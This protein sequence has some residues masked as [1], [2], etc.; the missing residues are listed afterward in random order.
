MKRTRA[1]T[2]VASLKRPRVAS[3]PAPLAPDKIAAEAVA[4]LKR[5]ASAK[6]RDGMGRYGIPSDKAL[7]VSVGTLHQV[8][9]KIGRSQE[10][11]E[12][13]W[14]TGVYEARLLAA[15]VG[16]AEK[17]TVAGMD[18]WCRGFDNWAVVD[19]VCF[20][21]FDRSPLAWG[22]VKPW[23]RQRGEFQ[24]RAG[25]VLLACLAAHGDPEEADLVRYLPLIEWGAADERNFVKK[26][27][28]WALRMMGRKSPVVR[29]AAR[30]TAQKLADSENA[31][32]RWVGRDALRDL[33]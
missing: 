4:E 8:A 20:K 18:R 19:T 6:V 27:V 15:F 32:A 1:R 9:R 22:R 24:R 33:K 23:A 2:A 28:S 29:S 12:L 30:D 25:F 11:A 7:G 3:K 21:L 17:L 14:E 31:S 5:L 13:L 16:E 26:G 10:V